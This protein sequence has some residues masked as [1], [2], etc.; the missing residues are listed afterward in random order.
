[1]LLMH[2]AERLIWILP[3][4][5]SKRA[6]S[7]FRASCQAR[8]RTMPLSRSPKMSIL[9]RTRLQVSGHLPHR[10]GVHRHQPD[11]HLGLRD[12]SLIGAAV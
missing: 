6:C 3:T 4:F 12:R 9:K 8:T 5:T 2:M 1:M 11:H 7:Y 10:N